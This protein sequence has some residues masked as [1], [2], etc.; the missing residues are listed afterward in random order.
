MQLIHAVL[1]DLYFS[2]SYL[3]D[4]ANH[5]GDDEE[6]CEPARRDRGEVSAV[7]ASDDAA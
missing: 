7:K 6:R 4:E 3:R 2:S 5:I 1:S